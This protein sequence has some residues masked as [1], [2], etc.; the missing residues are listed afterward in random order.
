[1]LWSVIP[2]YAGIYLFLLK[3]D[4][5]SLKNKY[6]IP[7]LRFA[8]SGMTRGENAHPSGITMLWSVIP[9]Y[10]GIYFFML[11]ADRRQ[12]NTRFLNSASLR[13]E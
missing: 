2:V 3:A 4:C 9:A 13:Q 6:Q 7:E 8:P 1:M 11:K 5:R 10:A 12:P